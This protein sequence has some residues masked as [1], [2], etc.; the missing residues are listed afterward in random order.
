[1][2]DRPNERSLH[3]HPIPRTGGLAVVAATIA[4]WLWIDGG[5]GIVVLATVIALCCISFIDDVRGLPVVGRLLVHLAAAASAVLTL[6]GETAF[7]MQ[8]IALVAITWMTNL[9]NFMDGSDGLAGG[10][11]CCGFSFYGAAAWLAGDTALAH[12]C[13]IVAAAAAG[14]LLWNFHPARIF[15]GDAGS[16]PLGFL[17][18]VLGYRGWTASAWP[19]W[20]PVVV[21][22]PFIVDASVT[23]ARRLWRRERVWQAHRDHYYQ[24][25][26]QL[27]WGHAGTAWTEYALMLAC[28]FAALY[29]LDRSVLGQ[30]A[31]LA[32]V[33]LVYVVAAMAVEG[34]WR[35]RQARGAP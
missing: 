8:L 1:V 12:A 25:L 9:F 10:M 15:L 30:V 23:L 33:G 24:R 16:V 26:V 34:A 31:L 4:G 32:A 6:G 22:S 7:W 3:A 19:W 11:A 18:G 29:A 2:I 13:W 27:G 14:F 5:M 17:A 28:G 21:F 35:T 20:F